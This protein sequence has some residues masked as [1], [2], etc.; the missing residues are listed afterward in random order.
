[1]QLQE[2]LQSL[3]CTT[4][5]STA[6]LNVYV[7]CCC[8]S[9][10]PSSRP[11]TTTYWT[12]ATTTTI[13]TTTTSSSRVTMMPYHHFFL[14]TLSL[15]VYEKRGRKLK[16]ILNLVK[17]NSWLMKMSSLENSCIFLLLYIYI[18]STTYLKIMPYY[19]IIILIVFYVS[20]NLYC[21]SSSKRGRLLGLDD[22]LTIG[23][24]TIPWIL[25]FT[26]VYIVDKLMRC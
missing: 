11:T 24:P 3:C 10:I 26:K 5:K 21:L 20:Q 25:I 14:S 18:F 12:N 13:F 23:W 7:G 17:N 15:F 19:T 22:P 6:S 9:W 16:E 4:P 2:I 8:F 1:M